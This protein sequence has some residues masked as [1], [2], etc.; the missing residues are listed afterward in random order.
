MGNLLYVEL[1]AFLIH[2]AARIYPASQE[3]GGN[4]IS[5]DST[6]L[7]HDRTSRMF[8]MAAKDRI[9]QRLLEK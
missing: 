7:F 5:F 1:G 2:V 8:R 9:R 6:N 3:R 4:S